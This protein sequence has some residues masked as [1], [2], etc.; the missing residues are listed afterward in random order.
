LTLDYFR[1]RA[2]DLNNFGGIGPLQTLKSK[3]I[4][5]ELTLSAF[6]Y[7]GKHFF[8]QG[9][10]SVALPGNAIDQELGS[11]AENWYTFQAALYMFF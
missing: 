1:H 8:F 2:N 7:I 10:A 6:Y 11:N 3:D 5:Q 9:I 4:G